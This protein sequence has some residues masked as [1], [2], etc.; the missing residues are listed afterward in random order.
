[1]QFT[2]IP[3]RE[4]LSRSSLESIGGI[5]IAII[6]VVFSMNWCI[7]F[8]LITILAYLIAD[9]F[10]R[11]LWF[12]KWSRLPK[13]IASYFVIFL[14]FALYS[15]ST[16]ETKELAMKAH[17]M[18]NQHSK[19]VSFAI[20]AFAG[21]MLILGYWLLTEKMF[22]Q[23]AG[24]KPTSRS[25]NKTDQGITSLPEKQVQKTLP[26]NPSP[27]DIPV[28][29]ASLSALPSN[30]APGLEINGIKWKDNFREYEF[31]ISNE[32]DKSELSDVRITLNLPWVIVKYDIENS[33]GTQEV[34][35]SQRLSRAGIRDKQLNVIKELTD[36]YVN[37][38]ELNAVKMFP[39]ARF[40]AR[41][42]LM[43]KPKSEMGSFVLEYRYMLNNNEPI[44]NAG[45]YPIKFKSSSDEEKL[46]IDMGNPYTQAYPAYDIFGFKDQ[47]IF[48]KDGTIT[49][50]K[51]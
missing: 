49:K 31:K 39:N 47:L 34:R 20:L 35:A 32:S 6:C 18:L 50:R 45:D 7:K 1:M 48:H 19:Y 37:N 26:N 36:M 24:G 25:E 12:S 51:L 8:A 4:P 5:A 29:K 2:D 17:N 30:Y 14:I 46:F 22:S 33:I 38:L 3:N 42:I 11:A 40:S 23:P 43:K 21:S 10:A 28:V 16:P 15:L 27:I 13:T 44:K 41:M 9:V